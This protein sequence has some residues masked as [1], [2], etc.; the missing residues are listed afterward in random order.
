MANIATAFTVS[1]RS[2]LSFVPVKA[3]VGFIVFLMVLCAV[4]A[5]VWAADVSLDVQD[6]YLEFSLRFTR[7]YSNTTTLKSEKAVVISFETSEPIMLEK[8]EFFDL[9]VKDAYMVGENFRKKLVV[10]FTDAVIEPEIFTGERLMKVRFN[11]PEKTAAKAA[12][13]QAVDSGAYG[14]MIY[15][16]AFIIVLILVMFWIFKKVAKKHVFTEIP[17]TGRLLGKVDLDFRKTLYFFELAET[18]YIIGV[19]DSSMSVIDKISDEV[20]AAVIKAGFQRK[21]EFSGYFGFFNKKND[22]DKD[23]EVSRSMIEEKLESLKRK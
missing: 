7:G 13:K 8:K 6:T 1:E 20:E 10:N 16:L 22:F 17:G 11:L 3:V 12:D 21:K 19:T 14:R 2:I 15:G 5:N 18:V 23:L 4:P 9:A